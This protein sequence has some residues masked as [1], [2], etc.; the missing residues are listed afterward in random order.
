MAKEIFVLIVENDAINQFVIQKQVE[1]LNRRFEVVANGEAAVERCKQR[2]F[3]AVLMDIHLDGMSGIEAAKQIRGHET[4]YQL[5]RV[6]I[7]A[8][9]SDDNPETFKASI[10][11][12]ID[13]ILIKPVN[14]QRLSDA[15][16]PLIPAQ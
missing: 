1:Q 4:T 6:P 10:Q 3:A 15:L 7:I 5:P 2:R 11:A 16:F 13:D 9:T 8:L 14:L 12:G